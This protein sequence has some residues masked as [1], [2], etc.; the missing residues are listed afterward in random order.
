MAIYKTGRTRVIQLSASCS[1]GTLYKWNNPAGPSGFFHWAE[2][3]WSVQG[4][5][6]SVVVTT[7]AAPGYVTYQIMTTIGGGLANGGGANSG[8]I[9]VNTPDWLPHSYPMT[10]TFTASVQVEECVE[11]LTAVYVD[12]N[13]SHVDIGLNSTYLYENYSGTPTVDPPQGVKLRFFER[14]IVGSYL[15]VS[16]SMDIGYSTGTLNCQI[17]SGDIGYAASSIDYQATLSAEALSSGVSETCTLTAT[18]LGIALSAPLSDTTTGGS[19]DCTSG[20]SATTDGVNCLEAKAI[21]AA[22]PP[23]GYN[24]SGVIRSV[25]DAYPNTLGLKLNRS[26]SLLGQSLNATSGQFSDSYSQQLYTASTRLNNTP[27]HSITLDDRTPLVMGMRPG[28][29]GDGDSYS[30]LANGEDQ[31]LWRVMLRGK[32]VNA[33]TL[34]QASSMNLDSAPVPARWTA[35]S[36]TTLSGSGPLTITVSGGTGSLSTTFPNCD[37]GLTGTSWSGVS[38]AGYRYLRLGLTADAANQPAMVVIGSKQWNITVGTSGSVDIDLCGPTNNAST[39]DATDS[40][41]EYASVG[42]VVVTDGP[43]SG[44]SNCTNF[45]IQGLANLHVYT[46]T[47]VKLVRKDHSGLTFLPAFQGWVLREPPVTSGS[48]TTTTKVR[49]FA[50][51]DTDG[52]QSLE[53]EDI[54]WVNIVNSTNSD[55]FNS[56]HITDFVFAMNGSSGAYPTDGWSATDLLSASDGSGN[57]VGDYICNGLPMLCLAGAGAWFD[58][59]RWRYAFDLSASSSLTL[60]AQLLFDELDWYPEAGDLFGFGKGLY[61]GAISVRAAAILRGQAWGLVFDNNILPANKVVVKVTNSATSA[62]AGQGTTDKRGEY[63]SGLTYGLG[64]VSYKIEAQSGSPFPSVTETFVS[65]KRHR[66]CFSG[67]SPSS[68][69]CCDTLFCVDPFFFPFAPQAGDHD[70]LPLDDWRQ[71]ADPIEEEQPSTAPSSTETG[72]AG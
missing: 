57:L 12:T 60:P 11:I 46:L 45:T 49:R 69:M 15:S 62:A 36:N 16:V 18:M 59:N 26:N 39:T 70:R 65:R 44:V 67:T 23:R 58:G 4:L 1:L 72:G 38:L 21:T 71:I 7:M 34:Q 32:L 2:P 52:R 20:A 53:L 17:T 9:T 54:T 68:L 24:L 42:P 64:L 55:Q 61:G 63:K 3:Q 56:G 66:A 47:S 19:A 50:Q 29:V 10:G 6:S 48:T 37:A 40:K 22:A 41:W 28:A 25:Q 35:G 43:L 33:V 13:S 14:P 8:L 5:W 31:T 30:L 51:G 27:V